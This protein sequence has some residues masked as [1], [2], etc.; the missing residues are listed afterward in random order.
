MFD[1]L[2]IRLVASQ[3]NGGPRTGTYGRFHDGSVF[4][5]FYWM[6]VRIGAFM[7]APERN[8]NVDGGFV[9]QQGVTAHGGPRGPLQFDR[10]GSR[11]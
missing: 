10:S 5:S 8:T 3:P 9:P 6:E 1:A 7:L 11:P 2:S 4:Y